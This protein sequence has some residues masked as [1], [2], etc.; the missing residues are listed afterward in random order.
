MRDD[1][2]RALRVDDEI[3]QRRAE[4]RSVSS[5]DDAYAD[6]R[7]RASERNFERTSATAGRLERTAREPVGLERT[8]REPVVTGERRFEREPV[9]S[10]E[11]EPVAGGR[12]F[13]R[14]AG[15]ERTPVV[16]AERRPAIAGALALDEPAVAPRPREPVSLPRTAP[17]RTYGARRRVDGHHDL[18]HIAGH[19]PGR[20]TVEITGQVQAPRR[21]SQTSSAL[22]ARPDRTAL[23]AFLFALF[24]VLMAVATAHGGG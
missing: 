17:G 3:P 16:T 23:W 14:E 22:V 4:L 15:A 21:R 11:R 1:A 20:R 6:L 7:A 19:Q 9:V 13:A 24:L 18:G 5:F 12:R 8:A 2:A 10:F